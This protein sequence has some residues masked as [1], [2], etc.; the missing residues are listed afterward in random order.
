MRSHSNELWRKA[1]TVIPGGVNSPVRAFRGVGGTPL[2]FK[3]GIGPYLIDVDNNR[4]VDYLNSWGPLILGHAHPNVLEA[5][6]KASLQGL[7]FG[8]PTEIEVEMAQTLTRLVPSMDQVRMVS[9]G[10]EAT[11]SAIRLARGYTG[12]K[13]IL[14]FEGGYHGHSDC[15]LVEA[16]S[17]CLTFGQPSSAGVPEEFAL[18]TLTVPYN[19]LAAV[20]AVLQKVG[21]EIAAIIVEPIAGNMNCIPPLPEFLPGLRKLCDQYQI[22]LIFDEV[23]TGFRVALGGAQSVFQVKPDLT[24]L[25]KI[26]GGGLPAAAFGGKKMIMDALSP[27]GPVYQAGT[28]SGNPIALSA[29]LATLKELEKPGFYT[30]LSENTQYFLQH[31]TKIAKQQG[32]P[33]LT[34]SSG[35]LFGL[36]FSEASQIRNY[37]E[38]KNCNK[39]HYIQFFHHMLNEG[40]YFAPSA[41]ECAYLSSAHTSAVLDYTL[42]AAEKVWEKWTITA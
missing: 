28:L 41:F 22:V 16:G 6:Q 39:E 32:I 13:K 15:L 40:V 10:T 4:Y 8:T 23:I 3:Q 30:R 35:S 12:R 26:I 25:G 31:L 18:H 29:G 36:F 42:E 37:Q 9:S 33:F 2:F 24:C 17:G 1:Q 11:Q 20:T 14:K 5:I 34:Q 27:E 21:E 19:D 38:A 7:S